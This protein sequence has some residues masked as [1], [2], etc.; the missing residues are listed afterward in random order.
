M[1][2]NDGEPASSGS[3]QNTPRGD[4][5]PPPDLSP[6]QLQLVMQHFDRV[7]LLAVA[8]LPSL[9]VWAALLVSFCILTRFKSPALIE[10]F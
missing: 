4:Q 6:E 9:P 7:C 2:S 8:S 1:G 3:P 10:C 5:L